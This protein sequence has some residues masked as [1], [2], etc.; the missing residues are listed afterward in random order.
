MVGSLSPSG[1]NGMALNEKLRRVI[2]TRKCVTLVTIEAAI[3]EL[4]EYRF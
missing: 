2:R 1:E 3:T 4:L